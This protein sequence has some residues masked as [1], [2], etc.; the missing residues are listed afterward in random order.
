MD[1]SKW[2]DEKGYPGCRQDDGSWDGGDT[3]AILGTIMALSPALTELIVKP[4]PEA[5]PYDV[6]YHQPLRHPDRKKWYGLPHRYSRDQL[7]A[8]LC[9]AMM[10]GVALDNVFRAHRERWFVTAWNT[11]KNGVVETPWKFPDICGPEVWALWIRF[12][13]PWWGWFVLTFLDVETLVGAITWRWFQPKT[14]QI[15]RNHMLVS[16]VMRRRQPSLLTPFIQAIND[17]PEMIARWRA[18]NEATG[19]FP[20]ADLFADF[21]GIPKP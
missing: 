9:G 15:C 2:L 8:M 3:A 6:V 19:E 21:L 5:C 11:R 18:S 1:Y 7:I 13:K 10:A 20:T 16:F 14:N 4:L 12:Y 17:Y